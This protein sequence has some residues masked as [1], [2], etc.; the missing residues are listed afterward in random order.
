[1]LGCLILQAKEFLLGGASEAH[2][3]LGLNR[4]FRVSFSCH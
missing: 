2:R 1:M 3:R 4:F